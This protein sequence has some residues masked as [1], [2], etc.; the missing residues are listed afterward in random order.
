MT[1]G[2]PATAT[3][4]CALYSRSGLTAAGVCSAASPGLH[5]PRPHIRLAADMT[6]TS[7]WL[8]FFEPLTLTTA[9]DQAQ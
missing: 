1:R 4:S 6:N 2:T 5:A 7:A 3:V 9:D 8:L